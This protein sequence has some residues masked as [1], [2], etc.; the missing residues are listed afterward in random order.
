M[1]LRRVEVSDQDP[2]SRADPGAR[3][4]LTWLAIGDLMID[5]DYQRPL[6]RKN[7]QAIQKIARAFD[8]SMFTPIIAAPLP[9]GGHALTQR[10]YRALIRQW[11][12]NTQVGEAA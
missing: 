3:P 12:R 5:D 6:Q 2:V 11:A 9:R 4:V 10:S 1:S 7:W 8:W